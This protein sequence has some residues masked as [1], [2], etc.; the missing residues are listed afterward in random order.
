ML[1]ISYSSDIII[2]VREIS[3]QTSKT[4]KEDTDMKNITVYDI[5]AEDM[6]KL[7][8][9]LDCSEA[10]LVEAMMEAIRAEG[11]NLKEYI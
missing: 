2:G 3:P 10:E 4:S 6:E 7:T 1:A 5:E 11:I 8:E 9:E